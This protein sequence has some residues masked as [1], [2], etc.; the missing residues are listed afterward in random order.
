M[1]RL[2]LP[3]LKFHTHLHMSLIWTVP[4]QPPHKKR[5]A[6]PPSPPVSISH[7]NNPMLRPIQF[8]HPSVRLRA[9]LP[10]T[11][12]RAVL[13]RAG[14]CGPGLPELE[15]NTQ[16]GMKL[17]YRCVCMLRG[18]RRWPRRTRSFWI[19]Y[20]FTTRKNGSVMWIGGEGGE[21]GG[22]V[23]YKNCEFNPNLT[24]FL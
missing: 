14:I 7:P 16:L 19:S 5:C 21:G 2:F 6:W 11:S 12:H 3:F 24:I 8:F 9:Q 17:W 10:A 1:I 22:G 4:E 20:G 18:M 13:V 23:R 15:A